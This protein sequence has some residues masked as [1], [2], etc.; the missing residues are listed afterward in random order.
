MPVPMAQS[1][2]TSINGECPFY[3]RIEFIECLAA[4]V[5]LYPDEV[6]RIAPGPNKPVYKILWSA[7]ALDRIEWYF[8][9]SRMRHSIALA[10]FSLL[11]SGTTSNEALHAEIN[12]WFRQTQQIHQ[13]TV[14]LKLQIMSLAKLIEH[15]NAMY[16]PTS[17]QMSASTLLARSLACPIWT[18]KS[19]RVWCNSLLH[20]TTMSKPILAMED[21]R[22][23]IKK[24]VKQHLMKRPAA[25]QKTVIKTRKR[26][27]FTRKR[28][29][30]LLS[31]G[32]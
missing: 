13:S 5:A 4:L 6:S 10:Q 20:N 16:R 23:N 19:W 3:S 27:A 9:N 14:Q 29:G 2:C 31:Q 15:N 1:L 25:V 28:E 8:N 7:A 32:H 12:N 24:K 18:S 30:R 26:T 17:R 22:T 21:T 11:H